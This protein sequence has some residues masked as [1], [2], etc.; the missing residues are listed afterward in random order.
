L[1]FEKKSGINQKRGVLKEETKRFKFLLV[2]KIISH[3]DP[4]DA[5]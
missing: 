5:I 4:Y 1:T 3:E 2:L